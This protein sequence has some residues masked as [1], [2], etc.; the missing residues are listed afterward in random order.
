MPIELGQFEGHWQFQRVIR[1]DAG[2]LAQVTGQ[3]VFAPDADGLVYDETGQMSLNGHAPL[4]S[5][6]RYLWRAGIEVLFDDGRFFHHLP[7][8]GQAAR[9][10]CAPD[11]YVVR[12][13]FDDWP[14]WSSHWRVDGPRKAYQMV[15][16]Y[17]RQLDQGYA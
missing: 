11:T 12:Y 7:E 4:T 14:R 3:A 2:H 17:T 10:C 16:D 8:P 5:T 1:H 15:T 6:R 13:M 9:H